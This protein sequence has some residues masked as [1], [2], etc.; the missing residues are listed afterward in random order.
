MKRF[1]R[2]A[3]PASIPIL[4]APLVAAQ[5]PK[6]ASFRPKASAT[7]TR[8]IPPSGGS[9]GDGHPHSPSKPAAS[10]DDILA[11]LTQDV[12]K[13]SPQR[14]K[15]AQQAYTLEVMPQDRTLNFTEQD[16]EKVRIIHPLLTPKIMAQ[17]KTSYPLVTPETMAR[18]RLRYASMKRTLAPPAKPA[19]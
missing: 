7:V 17:V 13:L 10:R 11:R 15:Q 12:Q 5:Q 14:A 18:V 8:T 4:L 1:F 9:S 2:I 16:A 6:S 3:M 19:N